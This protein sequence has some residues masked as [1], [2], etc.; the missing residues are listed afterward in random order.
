MLKFNILKGLFFKVT[1]CVLLFVPVF[2]EVF[3]KRNHTLLFFIPKFV[4]HAT[5]ALDE[6]DFVRHLIE[7]RIFLVTT[8]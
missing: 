4:K 7:N 5:Q 3:R 6:G 2:P 8:R 1:G